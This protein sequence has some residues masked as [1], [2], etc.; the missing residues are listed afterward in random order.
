MKLCRF[1]PPGEERPGV[2]LAD[3]PEKGTVSILDVRA[4]AFD[5]ADYD[6]HFFSHWGIERVRALLKEPALKL[7]RADG[8]RLGAPVA[9]PGKIVC[10]GKNYADHAAEFDA[11]L[12]ESPIYF[13]KAQSAIAGPFDPILLPPTAVLVD[14]EVELAVVI[15]CRASGISEKQA[16]GCIAGFTVLNDVTD[17]E[18]QKKDGQWFRAKSYDS[19]CPVGPF[20]VTPDEVGDPHGLRLYLKVG[21]KILQESDTGKMIFKI[22]LLISCLS[23]EITLEPGD[24][25]ATGTPGGIGSAHKPPVLLKPGD[26]VEVGV[27]KVG[28]QISPVV[29]G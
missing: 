29:A 8:V 28:V 13:C 2:W 15:G 12:P 19:F 22:P 21:D 9:H 6:A 27:E 23:R 11:K 10:L 1:G 26:T 7:V 24:I 3:T 14:G 20:L 16:M 18:A 5:I 4:M 25:I 17:R